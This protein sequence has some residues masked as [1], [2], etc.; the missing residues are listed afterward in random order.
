MAGTRVTAAVGDAQN[1]DLEST[2]QESSNS[3]STREEQ[4]LS[5]AT[6]V[7]SL[8]VEVE[9][10]PVLDPTAAEPH[11][12]FQ[13]KLPDFYGVIDKTQVVKAANNPSVGMLTDLRYVD[14]SNNERIRGTIPLV[15]SP[16][17]A[18]LCTRKLAG[19]WSS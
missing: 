6:L 14:Y 18:G 10:T 11:N 5:E 7:D 9:A 3:I 2:L 1:T 19:C 17:P 13:G 12:Q 8:Y 4:L 15:S 16:I